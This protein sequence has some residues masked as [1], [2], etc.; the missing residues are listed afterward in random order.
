MV[1]FLKLPMSYYI[2]RLKTG[3]S[4]AMV[5]Y[6]DGEWFSIIEHHLE[7][8]TAFGQVIH[9]Y[10]GRLLLD[11][12]HR[13]QAE[14]KFLFSVPDCMW[15]PGEFVD[16]KIDERIESKLKHAGIDVPFYERD[17]VFDDLAMAAGL[18]PFIHELRQHKVVV[19]GN[20]ALRGITFLNYKKFVGVS[21][22]NLHLEHGGIDRA[23]EEAA[24]F[25]STGVYLVCAGLSAPLIIDKLYE[26]YPNSFIIDCSSIWDAFVGLGGQR[27]WREEL[28][29]DPGALLQW[30]KDNLKEYYDMP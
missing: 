6:S 28:F 30:K 11:V 22:P 12:M 1:E 13:R 26:V 3:D 27:P 17:M 5:G 29:A 21:A 10:T 7:Q 15:K 18:Y 16:A 24:T 23:V 8:L 25:G 9:R 4:F 2:N 14:G 20:E 19:I